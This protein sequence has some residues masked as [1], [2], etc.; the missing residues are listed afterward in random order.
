M[1]FATNGLG[2]APQRAER[3]RM[4]SRTF[5]A[6]DCALGRSHFFGNGV[7]REACAITCLEELIHDLVLDFK[8]GIG[9]FEPFAGT[10]FGRKPPYE[11]GEPGCTQ[12]QP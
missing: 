12:V 2:I 1:K 9:F 4:L 11:C 6:G 10:G 3:R 7:L 5:E 8:C